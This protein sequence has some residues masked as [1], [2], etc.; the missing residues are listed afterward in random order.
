MAT[1]VMK[2]SVTLS[3]QPPVSDGGSGILGYIVEQQDQESFSHNWMRIDRVRA[4][5]YTY[6]VTNLTP[7]GSYRFRVIAENALGRSKSLEL[8]QSVMIKSSFGESL[9]ALSNLVV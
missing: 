4:H 3:W 6:N 7:G 5:I 9:V 8:R 2:S 1:D